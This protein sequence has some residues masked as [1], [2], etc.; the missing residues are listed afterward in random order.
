M[1]SMHVRAFYPLISIVTEKIL[2]EYTNG[3]LETVT[4][5]HTEPDGEFSPPIAGMTIFVKS[6]GAKYSAIIKEVTEVCTYTC[7]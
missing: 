7:V 3:E 2:V 1:M 4:T 6:K 5:I